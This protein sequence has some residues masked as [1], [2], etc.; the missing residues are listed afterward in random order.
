MPGPSGSAGAG[1]GLLEEKVDLSNETEAKLKEAR[2]LY[3]SNPDAASNLDAALAVLYGIEK[4]CRTNNDAASLVKVCESALQLC[5]ESKHVDALISTLQALATRRS[6]KSSAVKAMVTLSMPWCV[7]VE[8]QRPL[9]VDQVAAGGSSPSQAFRDKL[10]VALRDLSDGKLYLERERAILTRVLA[11]IKV[12][13]CRSD[14]CNAGGRR[15]LVPVVTL[16]PRADTSSSKSSSSRC[17]F[18][19][20]V[21]AVPLFLCLTSSTSYIALRIPCRRAGGTSRAR[22]T[23]C[24]TCTWK[25][26]GP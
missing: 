16:L 6:Q 5:F 18:F 20:V 8:K 15:S 9:D 3:E 26:T 22:P 23:C 12:R 21:D 1:E 4:K 11:T 7:D 2:S 24:R 10:V 19:L 17:P 13:V 25:R 14:A